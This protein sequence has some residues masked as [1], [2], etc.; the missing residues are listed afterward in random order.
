M[1]DA[2]GD[3]ALEQHYAACDGPCRAGAGI[4]VP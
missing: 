2:T 3:E 4:L 1:T